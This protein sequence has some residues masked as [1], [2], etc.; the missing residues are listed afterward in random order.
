MK[1]KVKGLVFVGFAAAILAGAAHAAGEN[2]VTSQAYTEATYQ[3]KI[4]GGTIGNE[5]YTGKAVIAGTSSGNETYRE[6]T[7]DGTSLTPD[8]TNLITEGAVAD[9]I[10]AVESTV[11]GSGYEVTSHKL[12]GTTGNTIGA[13]T[14]GENGNDTTMYPSAAAVK[15]Y[16]TDILTDDNNTPGSGYQHTSTADFQVGG[17]NGTWKTVSNGTYTT[18]GSDGNGGFKVDVNAL[19]GTGTNNF[20]NVSGG[21]GEDTN[22]LPTAAAVK[23]Y[24]DSKATSDLNGKQDKVAGTNGVAM[25]GHGDGE[26]LPVQDTTYAELIRAQD[27]N[28]A[29][30]YVMRV[31]VKDSKIANA[32]TSISNLANSNA[33]GADNLTTAW[34][35]KEAIAANNEAIE[36]ASATGDTITVDNDFHTISANTGTVADDAQTLTTGD[37]VYE[38]VQG[39]LTTGGTN[40]HGY[41][42]KSTALSVGGSNGSWVAA[43]SSVTNDATTVPTTAAVYSYVQSQTGG[44]VIPAQNPSIC[45]ANNYAP[46]ALVYEASGPH[47][48]TMATDQ[49]AGGTCGD[50]G[51]S[52]CDGQPDA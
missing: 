27:P 37:Q 2:I 43:A 32:G 49:H 20:A 28:D 14:S 42:E 11:S 9:A 10:A 36:Y 29:S 45:G 30:K 46:C 15:E 44:V 52:N 6:I 19:N 38:Y 39:Q 12:D 47:W 18:A 40:G 23:A 41:Q 34:A 35:V 1:C 31:A 5:I 22:K 26:W 13:T 3:H 48:R 17:A 4:K 51:D 8:S 25:V 50:L 33:I 24:V 7:D 21:T 16:V